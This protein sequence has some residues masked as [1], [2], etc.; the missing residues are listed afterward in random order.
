MERADEFP[1]TRRRM[2]APGT[3][4]LP[5]IALLL[6]QLGQVF[7]PLKSYI[8]YVFAWPQLDWCGFGGSLG[9]FSHRPQVY[10]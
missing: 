5:V 1:I 6:D 9:A 8:G 4:Q 2:A 7:E 3:G 10:P